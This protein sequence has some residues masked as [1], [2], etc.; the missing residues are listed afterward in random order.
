MNARTARL[1]RRLAFA[2]DRVEQQVAQVEGKRADSS[3]NKQLT[4]CKKAWNTSPRTVRG[5]QRVRL[6]G[7]F[8]T[9]IGGPARA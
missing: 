8:N 4:A 6:V 5:A 7:I 9:I 1:L 2:V 3:F